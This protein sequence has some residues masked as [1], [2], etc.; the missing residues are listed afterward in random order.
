MKKCAIMTICLLG[1]AAAVGSVRSE[2]PASAVRMEA[3][4]QPVHFEAEATYT[5]VTFYPPWLA[6]G[7]DAP[8]STD[9][10]IEDVY[11]RNDSLVSME[12]GPDGKIYVA[13]DAISNASPVRY[14]TGVAWS[15]DQGLTWN[16]IVYSST[17]YSVRYNE[18]SVTDDGKIYVWG[19][20]TG[21]SYTNVPVFMRSRIGWYNRPDTLY[22]WS[23]FTTLPYRVFPECVTW[24]GGGNLVLSQ[25]TIDRTGTAND[26]VMI[27]FSQD[28]ASF[29]SMTL[30]P[31]GGYPGMTSISVDVVGT[32]TILTHGIEYYD[33]T[34]ADWDVV[35]YL[36]TLNGSGGLYGW[37]TGNT[38]DD[39]YPSVFAS[40]GYAYIAYQGEISTGDHDVMFSHSTDYGANW[41][42][43]SDLT[44]NTIN[45]IYP[46][47][48][49]D[50][51]RI[52]VAYV[53][54][55]NRIGFT[56][57]IDNGIT[58]LTTPELVDDNST[59]A[60]AYHAVGLLYTPSYWYAAWLDSRNSGTDGIE[61]YTSRRHPGQGDI[62]HRPSIIT[63][64]Y[65]TG[66]WDQAYAMKYIEHRAASSIDDRLAD[67][68]TEA[69]PSARIPVLVML[70]RQLKPDWLVPRAER[71]SKAERRDFVIRECRQLANDDQREILAYLDG[72]ER[73]GRVSDIVSLWS[74]N[75][76]A[77]HAEPGVIEEIARRGDIGYIG[78]DERVEIIGDARVSEPS[79]HRVSF[80]P[81][82]SREICWGVA[83]INADDVWTGLGY[84]G[85]GVVVGHMDTG[86][87]YNH[88]DLEDHVWDGGSSYPN[89]GYDYVNEDDD[90]M[91]D[92]GHG[93]ATAGIVAGDGTRGSNTGVAP[94]AQIMALKCDGYATD[95]QQAIEFALD[96]GADLLSTSLGF[97]DP[98][99]ST[100]NWGRGQATTIY[101]AGLVWCVA[102][103]NGDGAGGHYTVPQDIC[104]PADAPS[105]YYAPNGGNSASIGVGA[106]T[107]ADE[108]DTYSSYGPT[109][110]E[111]T[112]S[113][114]DYIYPPGLMKPDVAA[115]GSNCKSLDYSNI[116]GYVTGIY[117]TSFA[118]PHVAGTVA[119]ML[120][121]NPALTPRQ[122]DSLLQETAL[123]IE[124]AGRDNYAGAGRI[125]AYQA[126]LAISAGAKFA[127]L[128]VINQATATGFLVVTGITK[129]ENQPWIVGINP[130]QFNV[131]INDSLAVWVSVD[132]TG[133][134]LVSGNIYYDTLLIWSNTITDDNPERVPVILDMGLIGVD[135]GYELVTAP[136]VNVLAII[137]NPFRNTVELAYALANRQMVRVAIYDASGKRVKMLQHGYQAAGDHAVV[138]SGTDD[139]GQPLAAGVYFARV[140]V[141]GKAATNK[142]ILMR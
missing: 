10:R 96:N 66:F 92:N 43:I 45:E 19:S 111:N 93:T 41:G 38:E 44:N 77:F 81:E 98:A 42:G 58:W 71:M 67:A 60:P 125:D 95:M 116:N 53:R 131:P 26:S 33:A 54:G 89:H 11:N 86:V 132:T 106:T 69:S 13:Y 101:A 138:W 82:D 47:L 80:T 118:Q 57:S 74:T 63:F 40:G 21:G 48:W 119:L 18:I 142:L 49:G 25:Y 68:M 141:G 94:D 120:E 110:W 16:N 115:P 103:G 20:L 24:G 9:V 137:P 30:R 39:R 64:D 91:D 5:G 136:P 8:W 99:N 90:P 32:D 76:V 79:V 22:G 128:W 37:G 15:E 88:R 108:V 73:E 127:Q 75:T 123:D 102:A 46:R 52:G 113:Y 124:A 4:P 51:Q 62:T 100:K 56:Y 27:M 133:Q 104:T 2:I 121:R 134:G 87:N 12:Y 129:D 17:T 109:H 1:L 72:K 35:C 85:A 130:V 114:N 112:G 70:A 83:Q 50:G 139:R 29:Y 105:P 61:I 6:D 135:E 31:S 23:G 7:R 126:V 59:V 122:I 3:L 65:T 55:G 117:G 140:E 78:P 28:T 14:G 36:D 84:T 97:S 34:G 107:V